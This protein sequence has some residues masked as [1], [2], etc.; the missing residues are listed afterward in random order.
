MCTY[1][2]PCH[3]EL[4]KYHDVGMATPAKQLLG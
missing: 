2:R 4:G 1:A 3:D